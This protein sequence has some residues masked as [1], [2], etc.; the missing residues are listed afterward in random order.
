MSPK[1]GI[2]WYQT[3]SE[4]SVTGSPEVRRKNNTE[5]S[6]RHTGG[7]LDFTFSMQ[8]LGI[9]RRRNQMRAKTGLRGSM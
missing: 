9:K 1:H 7:F 8:A 2:S 6:A 4:I 3:S 5:S